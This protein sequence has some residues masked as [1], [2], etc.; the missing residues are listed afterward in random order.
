MHRETIRL[1]M[2]VT[3]I[4]ALTV[5]APARALAMCNA[6][7]TADRVFASS[8][9]AVDRPYA[10]PG[11]EVRLSRGSCD[12]TATFVPQATTV[13][14]IFSPP[15]GDETVVVVP[16][17]SI[18]DMRTN[19]LA[20]VFPDTEALTGT[21][22]TGPASIVVRS[23]GVVTARIDVLG[24]RDPGC[25]AVKPHPIF[26]TFTALP[27]ANV[28]DCLADGRCEGPTANRTRV[29][30][31]VDAA[32]HLLVPWDWS[33][34]VP[35]GAGS[36]PIARLVRAGQ[37]GLEAFAPPDPRAGRGIVVP[38]GAYVS[39]HTLT[40]GVLPPFLDVGP[41]AGDGP[42]PGSTL[43]GTVDALDGVLRIARYVGSD[44]TNEIFDVGSRLEGGV[45]PIVMTHPSAKKEPLI[46]LRSVRAGGSVT[47]L[48]EYGHGAGTAGLLLYDSRSGRLG[49]IPEASGAGELP[50]R[51]AVS[52]EVAAFYDVEADLARPDLTLLPVAALPAAG[53]VRAT[54]VDPADLIATGLFGSSGSPGT[55]A[56]GPDLVGGFDGSARL[57]AVFD[58]VTFAVRGGRAVGGGDLI[59]EPLGIRHRRFPE[60]FASFD[61]GL[62]PFAADMPGDVFA[63]G[64]RAVFLACEG[65]C[66]AADGSRP[67]AV[68]K[69]L[70]A[71][72][73]VRALARN[74][75][76]PFAFTG[77]FVALVT[78]EDARFGGG[79]AG[80]ADL[81]GDGRLDGVFLT[82]Y[83]VDADR[84]FMP[85][86]IDGA[87]IALPP[88]GVPF[89]A[90]P[91]VLALALDEATSGRLNCDADHDD[92]V[93]GLLNVR[94][95]GLLN[96]REP[97]T[98]DG[99]A[100]GR[101]LL[102][103]LQPEDAR[104]VPYGRT[105][106]TVLRDSDGDEVPDPYD[107]CPLVADL[108]QP[109][110]D[111]DGIGDACD[112]ACVGAGCGGDVAAAAS[113]SVA[114]RRCLRRVGHAVDLLLSTAI[115]GGVRCVDRAACPA[116]AERWLRA[117]ARAHAIVARC[118]AATL[119]A[120]DVCA[121]TAGELIGTGEGC[122]A[123]AA[124]EAA[125]S[126]AAVR[127]ADT[128]ARNRRSCARRLDL[129]M[130]DYARRRQ[131]RLVQCRDAV[132]RGRV[133]RRLDGTI[134][135]SPAD[136]AA[137]AGVARDGARFGRTARSRIARACA[138]SELGPLAL[139]GGRTGN[140]LD[141]LVTADGQGGCLLASHDAA[142]ARAFAHGLA[143]APVPYATSV[144]CV[145][146]PLATPTP[147]PSPNTLSVRVLPRALDG[148]VPELDV[149]WTGLAHDQRVLAGAGFDVPLTCTG[150]QCEFHAVRTQALSAPLPIVAGGIG[151]CVTLTHDG[152]VSGTFDAS[153]G[154]LDAS[155]PLEVA[156]HLGSQDQP[157]PAC[158]TPDGVADLGEAGTCA[159]GPRGGSP[160]VVGGLADPAFG[161]SGS[162]S[163]DC[164]PASL[165]SRFPLTVPATTAE[166]RWALGPDSPNCTGKQGAKCHCPPGG[167]QPTQPHA[168]IDDSSSAGPACV[169][170]G[171]GDGVCSVL[172]DTVCGDQPWRG[173]LTAR[174][175]VTGSCVTRPRPCFLDTIVRT[176]RAEPPAGGVAH[177]TIVGTFCL[178]SVAQ[179]AVNA[180]AGFPGPGAFALPAELHVAR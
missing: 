171:L 2:L 58:V 79:D 86:G 174:D 143:A 93:L 74:P 39:S 4:G 33:G 66:A 173:C 155:L 127:A 139:C 11:R 94:R 141:A 83:D 103:F 37:S 64:N 106:L 128:V 16:P 97:V 51:F 114:E 3:L 62:A 34:V 163:V 164:P 180:A 169:P 134:V 47:A 129:A 84:S 100:Q 1:L 7:P 90:T 159:G 178:P 149:G 122:L 160:C 78:Y 87:P 38:N 102:T 49:R 12:G 60:R 167:T 69:L 175:C 29:L 116:G 41:A 10:S 8:I 121:D 161:T 98:A 144:P 150:D 145:P 82:L 152:V 147:Q 76:V 118:D 125:A 165:V 101:G 135:A 123:S 132:L 104:G 142:V 151:V 61:G 92:R 68:L 170:T 56:L 179:A 153:T 20:F 168:C 45:G 72:G 15:G 91:H 14:V 140:T 119:A 44:P 154:A 146:T 21:L 46:D 156:V 133:V 177:P 27:P 13:E 30:A 40:G 5:L 162:T 48:E 136:C 17:A 105:F 107:V 28:F 42:F 65:P 110:T 71:D 50:R 130:A 52:D 120:L 25:G 148:R 32:G 75:G 54:D 88:G 108:A 138:A 9:G 157:C 81:D 131:H 158:V 35:P 137:A 166:I 115:T 31:T 43:V 172:A 19:E 55:P 18:V 57:P 126:M 124:T 95:H 113:W 77:G 70:D 73:S 99:F 59:V 26:P 80:V 53:V 24:S 96:T 109:D 63:V 67:D 23:D 117:L 89:A 176:G 85:V 6:I 112:A 111:Q 36:D 22:R